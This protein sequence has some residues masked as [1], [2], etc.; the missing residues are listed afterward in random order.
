MVLDNDANTTL[1]K[2]YSKSY[3]NAFTDS[4]VVFLCN[5]MRCKSLHI[6]VR[7]DKITIEKTVVNIFSI[8][9]AQFQPLLF[10][11]NKT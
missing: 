9:S 3:K 4:E 10:F 11:L 6:M 5:G 1:V 8:N 2:T 7:K